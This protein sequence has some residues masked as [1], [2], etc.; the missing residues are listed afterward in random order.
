MAMSTAQRSVQ[1]PVGP[2]ALVLPADAHRTACYPPL[3]G[4]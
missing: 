3:S 1:R 2:A 4:L